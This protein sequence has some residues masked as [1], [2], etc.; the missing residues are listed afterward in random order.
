MPFYFQHLF[1]K[2]QNMFF[3]L[4]DIRTHSCNLHFFLISACFRN[5][6][7]RESCQI[8]SHDAKINSIFF[9]LESKTSEKEM[10]VFPLFFHLLFLSHLFHYI[11]HSDWPHLSRKPSLE[12]LR[13]PK[14]LCSIW[15]LVFQS[16]DSQIF[17]YLSTF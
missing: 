1:V 9:A 17:R 16:L 3:F 4:E 11:Y 8:S 14:N 5:W 10:Q 7:C 15:F 12:Q 13:T 2:P 6:E